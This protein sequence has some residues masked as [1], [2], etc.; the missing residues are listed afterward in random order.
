MKKLLLTLLLLVT[1]L[2][3]V[4]TAHAA[5]G[6]KLYINGAEV[7]CEVA[8]RIINDRT[9]VPVRVIF[10]NLDAKVEWD[11]ELYQVQID[12]EDTEIVFTI[13]SKTAKVNGKKVSLD[14]APMILH[15]RTLVPIRFVSENLGYKVSWNDATKSVFITAPEPPKPDYVSDVL[16]VDTTDE[17]YDTLVVI[18]LTEGVKPKV[19]TLEEPFRIILDFYNTSLSTKDGKLPLGNIYISEVRWALHEEYSRIVIETNGEQPYEITGAGTDKVKIRVGSKDSVPVEPEDEEE[20]KISS[21]KGDSNKN[22]KNDNANT[23]ESDEDITDTEEEIQMVEI[24]A[25]EDMIIVIDAGHG[26]KDVGAVAKDDSGNT[27]VDSDGE[28]VLTEKDLNLYIAQKIRDILEDNDV[29][30]LM[31][32][33]DDTFEGTNMENLVA[34]AELA[35]ENNAMLFVSIHNNSAASPNATGTEICYTEQSSGR[36]GITSKGL[37]KNILPLLVKA[38]GLTNRGLVNRPNL[39]VLKYTGMPAV[40]IEC[41]FLTCETDREVLM[42]TDKLDDI[43]QAVSDGIIKSMKEIIAKAEK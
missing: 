36:Y 6:I 11:P 28:P 17:E 3:T 22:D 18:K 19:M 25:F 31:T 5:F 1:L 24:P 38:T 16:S 30:V 41:G 10:E 33:D 21:D 42:D 13:G 26:G 20:D 12:S 8:P 39:V 32:R 34:R 23:N 7:E 35:N 37:A 15:D 40:L 14:A 9:M 2:M 43:A 29:T 4:T 27:I